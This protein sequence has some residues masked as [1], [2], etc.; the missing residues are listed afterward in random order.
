MEIYSSK[1]F[2]GNNVSVEEGSIEADIPNQKIFVTSDMSSDDILTALKK[3]GKE[4][5]F[6]KQC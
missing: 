6:V 3:T 2:I 5:S 4:A 1:I